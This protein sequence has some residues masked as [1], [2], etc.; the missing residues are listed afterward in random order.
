MPFQHYTTCIRRESGYCS[1]TWSPSEG[2]T[3]PF[4][5]SST[6]SKAKTN[7]QCATDFVAIAEGTSMSTSGTYSTAEYLCGNIFSAITSSTTAT[8]VTSNVLPF[9][10]RVHTNELEEATINNGFSLDYYQN[11][12]D[13]Y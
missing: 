4:R 2:V 7:S 11:N 8:A 1:I 9:R 12:C 6:N 13:M 10:L 3:Y 5:M